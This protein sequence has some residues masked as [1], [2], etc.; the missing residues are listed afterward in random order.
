MRA[1]NT[2]SDYPMTRK[3]Y[4]LRP[5]GCHISFNWLQVL[6][7]P[8]RAQIDQRVRHQC[9]AI[10]R[11][12]DTFKSEPPPLAF[13]CP[14]QGPL[15]PHP[16]RMDHGME[17]PLAPTLGALAVARI[18]WDV[19]HHTG[20]ENARAIGCSIKAAI[21]VA[22]SPSEVQPDLLA[23]SCNAFRPSGPKTMSVALTGA[24]GT[25]ART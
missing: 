16:S 20:M 12:L 13:V 3:V 11:L 10:V 25:G 7:A 9:H 21:K 22:R 1:T 18:L 6:G 15:D 24:T 2:L 23:T 8:E 14:R 4:P 5:V 17:Q 19:G